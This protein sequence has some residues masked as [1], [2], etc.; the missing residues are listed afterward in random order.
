VAEGPGFG[1]G[2]LTSPST[3]RDGY[4]RLIDLAPTALAALGRPVPADLFGG[5]AARRG[6]GRPSDLT[7]AVD[8]LADA[9]RLAGAQRRVSTGFFTALAVGQLALYLALVPLLRRAR[10]RGGPGAPGPVPDR[11]SRVAEWALIAAA[12]ATP[13]AMLAGVVPWWRS[14]RPG[15]L[16]T[17]IFLVALAGAT[18][19]TWRLTSRHR[20]LGPL[21]GVAAAV[22]LAVGFDVLTGSRLQ[23][24]G[25]AGYSAL[26]GGRYAGIGTI[27]LGM[28]VG[29]TLLAAACLAQ[30][31]G[32]RWR[33]VIVAAIGSVG[34]VVVGSPYF[35][36]NPAGAVALTAGVCAAAAMS[37][38]GWLSY[39]RLA[40]AVLAGLALTAA[41]ALLDVRRPVEQ[42]GSVGRFLTHIGDGSAGLVMNRTG[43]SS[44]VTL[45]SSPL[46][47]LVIGAAAFA[48]LVLLR[49]WG[50]L[51]RL[52]GLFPAV[53]GALAGVTVA[54]LIAGVLDGVGLNITG[55]ALA[56]VLPLTVLALL[57]VQHHADDRTPAVRIGPQ[58][59]LRP[60][61]QSSCRATGSG[62]GV[63]VKSRG[64]SDFG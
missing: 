2:W 32:R 18:A 33:P 63:T 11:T 35:G 53:R 3:G 43:Q 39:G 64:S 20:A 28:L 7:A 25:I 45:A 56:V 47:V 41:F 12:L 9:D 4:V 5:A 29:G 57:R 38:G 49:P 59:D 14:G 19:L 21:G 40:G 51:R 24:D 16:F 46:T 60:D 17:V 62:V 8:R 37:A 58:V 34:V 31:A 30:R 36:A 1:P 44:I 27:G 10:P 23:L 42:R 54:T 55:A 6:A 61:P 50:G 22:A 15:L 52:Y 26:A 13:A 48:W